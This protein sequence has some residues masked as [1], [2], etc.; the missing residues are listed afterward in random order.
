MINLLPPEQKKELEQEEIF[1]LVLILGIVILAF[2]FSLVLILFS[3]KT[4]LLVDL[5]TQEI[6]IEQEQKE[7]EKP[8]MRE[9]EAKIKK[10]NST[11]SK[12]EIFY[13]SQPN[14]TLILEKIYRTLPEEI[15]LTSFNFNPQVS[16]VSLD[17]FS[18]T[19]EILIRFRENLEGTKG[20][21]EIEFPPTSWVYLTDIKFSVNFKIE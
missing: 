9:L 4:S 11:L 13:Q 10:N 15:Y 20:F 14:L 16:Q 1:K 5:N 2:L 8:E 7:L 21:K 6:Y 18:P 17:G 3:I 19:R 12:L